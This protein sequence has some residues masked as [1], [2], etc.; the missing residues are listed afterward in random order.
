MSR[1]KVSTPD[2]GPYE[3]EVPIVY[4]C[5]DLANS[6]VV[7]TRRPNEPAGTGFAIVFSGTFAECDAWIEEHP[8]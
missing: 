4:G 1:R 5:P 7:D 6:S 8:E 2:L 3:I